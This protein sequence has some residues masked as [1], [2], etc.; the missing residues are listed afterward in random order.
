MTVIDVLPQ[1]QRA[2]KIVGPNAVSVNA[3]APLPDIEPTD[4]LVRVVCVS[5]NPVDGKAADMSPQLGATSG[6]DFSGVVVALGADV[7]ADNWREANTMKPVRIGDRVFG[8]IFG[9]DPLRPHNGAFADY[10]A[11]PARLV[12]H[13]PTGTDFATAATMGAAIA[14]VGLSLFNYLGLPLP[15]KSKAGLPV[16]TTCSAA[17]STNVLQL[18]AEAWF[19]YKSP[20]CGADIREHTNDSL[21]F[22]LDCITDTASMGICYE[23][24]GSA[25]GRYVALDAFPVRGHTRRSVVPE[26]VCTPTQFGKAIRWTPPYDLEPRPYDLKCAEL[27]YVV[28]Q[29]LID[30]GLIASHPLEKRNGGLS[31]VPEGMEE[32]RRGQIKGKK[33]VYTI[34]DSEPIAVSA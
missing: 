8:G 10:V 31:A 23:A 3:A 29:R 21:A 7:E 20:T 14:T 13:I 9:N 11:V 19:D 18:G 17:S 15:S 22:A 5:I 32:V 33:L 4:V 1:T 30:E 28:A 16:V 6:T 27:W 2:L 34:L 26:W 24:L 25:G 12:W